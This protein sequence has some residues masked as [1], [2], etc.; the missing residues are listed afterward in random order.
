MKTQ[1]ATENIFAISIP[2]LKD[3]TQ[4]NVN[5]VRCTR[6]DG[7]NYLS[8][9]DLIMAACHV[10]H[11]H[12]NKIFKRLLQSVSTSTEVWTSCPLFQFEGQGQSKQPVIPL[13]AALE[14]IMVLPGDAAKDYRAN[15]AKL[16]IRFAAGDPTLMAELLNN[17]ESQ[18]P[19]NV[20]AREELRDEAA[21]IEAAA[22]QDSM[23]QI[24]INVTSIATSV[25]AMSLD[26]APKVA[27][28][29][30]EAIHM[31]LTPKVQ[32]LENGLVQT[33][34]AKEET[35]RAKHESYVRRGKLSGVNKPLY[36]YIKGNN[37]NLQKI[38]SDA[39]VSNRISIR[40]AQG[41]KNR[42]ELAEQDYKARLELAE[43]DCKARLEHAEQD[44]KARLEL[45]EQRLKDMEKSNEE[46]VAALR[47]QITVQN[48][49]LLK[50]QS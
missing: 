26:L 9:R 22:L 27:A 13:G 49:L 4:E 33:L 40:A 47:A 14:L 3:A 17:A 34:Q 44:Y 10:N 35:E 50:Q 12:A 11:R 32:A 28:E 41:Y 25:D 45:V 23:Q 8:V 37:K 20:L 19:A 7:R 21:Q 6:L 30:A 31:D 2:F 39:F 1:N 5:T 42:L 46:L 48:T 38:L 15:V 29:V 24:S 43:Q 16:L 18:A 36:R